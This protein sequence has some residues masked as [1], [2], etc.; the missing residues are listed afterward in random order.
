MI[1]RFNVSSVEYGNIIEVESVVLALPAG[2]LVT[3]PPPPVGRVT[4]SN[5]LDHEDH[6]FTTPRREHCESAADS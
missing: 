3:A 2:P 5:Q 6:L 1:L 4:N